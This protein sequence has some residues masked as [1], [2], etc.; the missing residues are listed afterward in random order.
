MAWFYKNIAPKKIA[1]RLK[2]DVTAV[3]KIIRDNKLLSA[4]PPPPKKRT[5][6]PSLSSF[7]QQDRLHWYVLRFPFKTG[8]KLKAKVQGWSNMSMRT[9]QWVWACRPTVEQRSLC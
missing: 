2:R 3:W 1:A 7:R 5:G 9:I 8:R 4:T 6:R